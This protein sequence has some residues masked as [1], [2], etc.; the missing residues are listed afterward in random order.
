MVMQAD[1]FAAARARQPK[2]KLKRLY[3]KGDFG[4]EFIEAAKGELPFLWGRLNLLEEFY[5]ECAPGLTDR[6]RRL[7]DQLGAPAR[8]RRGFLR[9]LQKTFGL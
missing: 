6:A 5:A 2:A 9:W 4:E 1:E 7:H 8:Y 3:S